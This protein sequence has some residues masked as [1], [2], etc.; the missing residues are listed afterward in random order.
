MNRFRHLVIP[1]RPEIVARISPK[2]MIY[3]AFYM[4]MEVCIHLR[5]LCRSQIRI[6][7]GYYFGSVDQERSAF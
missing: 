2:W 4:L 1:S 7:G 6:Q 5:P 3:D